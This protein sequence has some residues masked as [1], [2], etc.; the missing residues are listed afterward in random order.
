MKSRVN[1]KALILDNAARLE[2]WAE[3]C[4]KELLPTFFLVS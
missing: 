3:Q 1:M 4:E 2:V